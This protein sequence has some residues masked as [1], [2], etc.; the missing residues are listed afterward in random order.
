MGIGRACHRA[1]GVV[2]LTLA[3]SISAASVAQVATV[4]PFDGDWSEGFESFAPGPSPTLR[5]FYG[6]EDPPQSHGFMFPAIVLSESTFMG[7]TITAHSGSNS[8]FPQ[9]P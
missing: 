5:V 9:A 6:D 7:S 2:A 4:E 1:L 8:P 3:W